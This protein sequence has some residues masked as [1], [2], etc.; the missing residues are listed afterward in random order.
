MTA[1]I[2]PGCTHPREPGDYR[3]IRDS[4]S[5]PRRQRICIECERARDR[6]REPC[7]KLHNLR[8][9]YLSRLRRIEAKVAA[10]DAE[11][12]KRKERMAG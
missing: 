6:R 10:I 1:T 3:V 9:A 2:C 7:R 12:A 11:L 5:G 8:R 4:R